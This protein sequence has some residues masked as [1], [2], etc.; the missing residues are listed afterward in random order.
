M[1]HLREAQC[2]D[3][4]PEACPELDYYPEYGS[5]TFAEAVDCTQ[6]VLSPPDPA[7]PSTTPPRPTQLDLETPANDPAGKDGPVVGIFPAHEH[8][9]LPIKRNCV[10]AFDLTD[11]VLSP[12]C[13]P[14]SI[15]KD[16]IELWAR[17]FAR[18]SQG[19]IGALDFSGPTATKRPASR[20]AGT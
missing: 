12:F 2:G 20:P 11:F 15:P 10:N 16:C 4:L 3:D 1:R 18:V 14:E 5:A 9:D 6:E 13:P 8:G 17:E 7:P 19:L